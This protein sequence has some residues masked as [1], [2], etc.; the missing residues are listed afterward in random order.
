MI[1]NNVGKGE[2]A[3]H[4]HFLLFP[5]RFLKDFLCKVVESHNCAVELTLYHITL[6]FNDLKK[7]AFGKLCGKKRKCW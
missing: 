6:T 5:T 1:E 7:Q 3:G 2:N 4:Q